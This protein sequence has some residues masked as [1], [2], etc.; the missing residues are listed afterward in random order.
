MARHEVYVQVGHVVS[1]DVEVDVLGTAGLL[2]KTRDPAARPAECRG[3]AIPQVAD[4]RDVPPGST[5]R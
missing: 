4:A 1:H 5:T 3:F 2:E